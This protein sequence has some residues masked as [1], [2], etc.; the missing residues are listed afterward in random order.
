MSDNPV[1]PA[2]G[3]GDISVGQ[4]PV[5]LTVDYAHRRVLMYYASES[6]LNELAKSGNSL[7]WVFFGLCAGGL[8]SFASVLLSTDI[9]DPK[10]YATF[11]AATIVLGLG[12]L[13]FGVNGYR[14][15]ADIKLTLARIK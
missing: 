14:D 1:H 6:E 10:A 7:N 9:R 5:P 11:I 3:H 4:S 8:S 2:S 12:A 13:F 15:Y